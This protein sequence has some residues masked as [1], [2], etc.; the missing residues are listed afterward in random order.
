MQYI[1]IVILQSTP[2]KVQKHI[3]NNLKTI[4]YNFLYWQD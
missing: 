2:Y 1:A 4:Q 3:F